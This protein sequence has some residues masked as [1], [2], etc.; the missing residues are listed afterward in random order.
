MATR[1]G[2]RR[3]PGRRRPLVAGLALAVL[4]AGC[5]GGQG[6]APAAETTLT[7]PSTT[8]A[9]AVEPPTGGGEGEGPS[10]STAA[11]GPGTGGDPAPAG[12][13]AAAAYALGPTVECLRAG[14]T[15]VTTVAELA[16]DEVDFQLES[17]ADLAQDD[18]RV[19]RVGEAL[20]GLGFGDTRA[21][22]EIYEELLFVPDDPYRITRV[23]NVVLLAREPA[24][25]ALAAVRPCLRP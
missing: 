10:G 14:G 24:E 23:E 16:D 18:A 4:A 21:T 11:A 17:L 2:E 13:P 22:A 19:A 7:A 25:A 3:A 20:V 9:P 6:P 15:T 8:G 12:D 5:S 1:G